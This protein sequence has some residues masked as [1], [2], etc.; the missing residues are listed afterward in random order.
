MKSSQLFTLTFMC[1]WTVMTAQET[2]FVR[3]Y[4]PELMQSANQHWSVTQAGN[5]FIYTG[6]TAGM[7]QYDGSRWQLLALPNRQI[8]RIVAADQRGNIFCGGFATF[9]YW[10]PDENGVLTYHA[11]SDVIRNDKIDKEEIWHIVVL[12]D[13][14]YFQS[15]S[16]LYCYDYHTVREIPIPGNIMFMKHVHDQL[17]FPVIEKGLYKLSKDEKFEFIP[18]T[19]P[20]R[21][22][23]VAGITALGRDSLLIGTERQGLF[24]WSQGKLSSWDVPIQRRLQKTRLNKIKSLSNGYFAI[25]TVGDGLFLAGRNGQII[26]HIHRGNGLQNNT[27]LAIQEDSDGNIWV[28]MD[29]GLDLVMLDAPLRFSLDRTGSLGTVYAACNYD[30]TLYLGTNQGLFFRAINGNL[31][32]EDWQ[33]VQGI[34]G[35]VWEL[36]VFDGQLLCGHNEGTFLIKG[37]KARKICAVTG[38]WTTLVCPWNKQKLIQGTYTG[39]VVMTSGPDITFSHRIAGFEEPIEYMAFDAQGQLW[40]ANPYRGVYQLTLSSDLQKVTA[41][42]RLDQKDGLSSDF[43]PVLTQIRGELVLQAGGS[44]Y[45]LDQ[46]N[47]RWVPLEAHKDFPLSGNELKLMPA[48]DHAHFAIYPDKVRFFSDAHTESFNLR[49]VRDRPGIFP[50]DPNTWLL[51]LDDGYALYHY[52]RKGKKRNKPTGPVITAI[53]IVGDKTER[54]LSSMRKQTDD[55]NVLRPDEQ[56]IIFHFSA[57]HFD[58]RPAF[59]W[60]LNGLNDLWSA[61]QDQPYQEFSFLPPGQY[62]FELQSDQSAGTAF[63]E[64]SI[65]PP[66]YKTWQFRLLLGILITS[67]LV[68]LQIRHRSMLQ[69]RHRRALLERERQ[70]QQQLIRE[71]NEQLQ[72]DV[73]K[74]AKDLANSTMQLIRKNEVLLDIRQRIHALGRE[75]HH[76][77]Q[78]RHLLDQELSSENDWAV[79]EENFNSVHEAFLKKLKHRFPEL[80]PGDL[81]L[82]AYLKMNLSSKEIAPLMGISIRGLENKRYRLRKK[83]L[84]DSDDNLVAF[85]LD[86]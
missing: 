10:Q 37:G 31:N 67:L 41:S 35:Q 79:F 61:W 24:V 57:L 32:T 78:L 52:S 58:Q 80:T 33:A 27:V 47:S 13:R 73:L 22:Q 48:G 84:L 19:A 12:P 62:L 59:R 43:D 21:Q 17:I 85:L 23:I 42:K 34:Q 77:Q 64:F 68:I 14:V 16:A 1:V 40:A 6:N 72:E 15:F 5:R 75:N 7:M 69:A 2:P 55:L 39:L 74:K 3:N 63:F 44:F 9:G 49:M 86:F 29:K 4:L 45:R 11:L 66:W 53:D 36:N 56:K 82:A 28:G 18:G 46:K 30:Q 60:R 54:T 26:Y 76:V 71:R 70:L 65:R 51:C 81:R 25:G 83:M 20:L 50:F 38:G 8:V